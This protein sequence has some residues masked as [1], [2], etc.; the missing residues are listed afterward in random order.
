MEIKIRGK[1]Y[2]WSAADMHPVLLTILFVLGLISSAVSFWGWTVI[3]V[4]LLG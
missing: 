1:R 2:R 4:A 3:T